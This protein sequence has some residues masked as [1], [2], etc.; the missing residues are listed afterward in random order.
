MRSRCCGTRYRSRLELEGD[1]AG[2]LFAA[3]FELFHGDG[4]FVLDG[5]DLIELALFDLDG[6][7]AIEVVGGFWGFSAGDF[8]IGLA[9]F[10]GDGD[11]F[12]GSIEDVDAE[13]AFADLREGV[14]AEGDV[15]FGDVDAGDAGV[16]DGPDEG[17]VF[18][19][20]FP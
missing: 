11:A 6:E 12:S 14:L 4:L 10:D 17:E 18:A 3:D 13:F 1:L 20:F 7:V 16:V 5:V 2:F 15:A 19:G 8:D 9:D